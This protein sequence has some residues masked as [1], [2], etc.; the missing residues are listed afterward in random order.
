MACH[1]GVVS[2]L[3][4]PFRGYVPTS[5]FAHRVVGPPSSML[6]ADQQEAARNDPLSFRHAAGRGAGSSQTEVASWLAECHNQGV[7]RAVGPTVCVYQQGDADLAATGII[8]DVRLSAYDS[9]L[10]KRHERTIAKTQRKMADY[11][12][13]TRIFGNPV[14]LTHRPHAGLQAT[15]K[16]HVEREADIAFTTADSV[17]HRLWAIEGDAAEEVCRGFDNTLYIT[18]GHHRLAAASLVASEEG[19]T[20]ARLPVALFSTEALQLRSFARCV[21]DPD[22][23]VDNVIDRLGTEHRIE[24]VNGLE[25]RPRQRFEVGV[26]IRDRYFRLQIDRSRIPD[27]LFESL[28]VNLLQHLILGPVFGIANGRRDKRLRFF[29]DIT[30]A[31]QLDIESDAWLLPFPTAVDDVM[32]VAD[33]GRVMPAKSTWFA[34]KVPSGLVIRS[35]EAN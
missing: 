5:T 20:E 9:G 29:A 10:V 3:L 6:S 15:I 24:E 4:K 25:A 32:A 2:V 13:G 11:M 1:H 22:L 7:L 28:D 27:D 16:A 14:A 26:K 12:R 19:R 18:D 30:D 35:L 34:P 17:S 23:D 21:V 8:A 33:S 31:S